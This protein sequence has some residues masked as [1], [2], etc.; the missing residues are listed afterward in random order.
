MSLLG[1]LIGLAQAN[2]KLKI[3]IKEI[4]EFPFGHFPLKITQ[5]SPR[6]KLPEILGVDFFI[7]NKVKNTFEWI[8][9]LRVLIFLNILSL[10]L[11]IATIVHL[12]RF[13]FQ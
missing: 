9:I 7:F 1:K 8:R 11:K 12:P 2:R 6:G 13:K 3:N 4:Q 5:W 10:Q